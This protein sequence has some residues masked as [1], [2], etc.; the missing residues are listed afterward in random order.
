MT[1]GFW[2]GR[3]VLVTGH[4]GFKGAW[5][6]LWLQRVGA[7]AF[8]LALPPE[9]RPNLFEL[10]NIADNMDCSLVDIRDAAAVEKCFVR[11]QPEIVFHLAAQSLVRRSYQQ[12]L[13]TFSTNIMG[14]AHVLEAVRGTPGIRAVVVVTTDKCYEDQNPGRGYR[15][16]DPLGGFDPYSSSKAGAEIVTAAYR[17]SYFSD[18]DHQ[19]PNIASARAGN[20]IGGGDWSEDRLLPD[21]VRAFSS[22]RTAYLRNPAAVRPWQHVLD[23]LAGYMHLAEGLC[24]RGSELA[25]AW[26][27]GPSAAGQVSVGVVADRAA[28]LWGDGAGYQTVAGI[29][30]HET[31]LLFLDAGKAHTGLNWHPRLDFDTS[32]EWTIAWYK[33]H[34]R[35]ANV[36]SLTEQQIDQYMSLQ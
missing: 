24:T 1:P 26:N 8:G 10:A 23:P 17:R 18:L 22:G 31:K 16:T 15:E 29:H 12:P 2:K 14:T 20:V 34:A 28:Q 13:N 9:T 3:R 25:Q 36:R 19:T 32:M 11:V 7:S 21:L 30:P 35:G 33:A 6:S 27:F 5:I 4:T